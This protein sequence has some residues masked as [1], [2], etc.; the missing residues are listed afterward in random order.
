MQQDRSA[1]ALRAAGIV[2]IF[3][4]TYILGRELRL[5]PFNTWAGWS[6]TS[7]GAVWLAG[8]AL[9]KA[10]DQRERVRHARRGQLPGGAQPERDEQ[11]E[12]ELPLSSKRG[13]GAQ[14]EREP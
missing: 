2:N 12:P 4:G 1:D 6:A 7:L 10:A 13:A 11:A 8:A 3:T 9:Q 5:V 14:P